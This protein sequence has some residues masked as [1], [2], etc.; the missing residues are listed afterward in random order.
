MTKYEYFKFTKTDE[1]FYNSLENGT[2]HFSKRNALND[3]FDCNINIEQ[4]IANAIELLSGESKK[5]LS[6]LISNKS[7][8]N[9]LQN[10]I[11]AFG[12]CSFSLELRET[13][14]WA[15]Y[16]DD[17]KGVCLL[18]E[19]PKDYLLDERNKIIGVS[20]VNYMPDP[21]TRWFE[22]IAPL[23]PL[24]FDSFISELAKQ[25]VTAKA[26]AWMYEKEARIIR[27]DSGL[28]NVPK[29]F[30]KQICFG[31]QT[32]KDDIERITNIIRKYPNKVTMCKMTRSNS[33][34]GLEIEEI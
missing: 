23:A 13:L 32:D 16:A 34:F 7:L 11:D 14:M 24:K 8:F 15:H 6:S 12:I 4:S 27:K 28:L 26:P 19:F 1:H 25:L 31:L 18:Y 30:V 29:E 21:L 3:P 5:S 2:I 10:D 9:N 20:K 22:T 33:D 17:H